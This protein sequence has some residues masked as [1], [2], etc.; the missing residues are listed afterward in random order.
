M[1][2]RVR[3]CCDDATASA[4]TWLLGGERREGEREGEREREKWRGRKGGRGR[5]RE[6][7]GEREREWVGEG[8]RDAPTLFLGVCLRVYVCMRVRTRTYI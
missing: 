2:V 8:E 4:C 7:G 3:A 6:G 5:W 1:V